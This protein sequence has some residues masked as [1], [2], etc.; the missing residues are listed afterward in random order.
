MGNVT[1]PI[2]TAAEMSSCPVCNQESVAV[3]TKFDHQLYECNHCDHL[4]CL[5]SQIENYVAQTYGDEYF[6]GADGGYVNYLENKNHLINQGRKYSKVL[7]RH[8]PKGQLLDIGSAAG[9]LLKGF[10]DDGWKGVGIEPNLA[11]Q[12]YATHQLNLDVRNLPFDDFETNEKFDAVSLIQVISHLPDLPQTLTRINQLLKP[13]GLFLIE[14]WNRKSMTARVFSKNWH[15]YNPPSV[16]HWFTKTELANLLAQNGFEVIQ[17][18]RPTKWISIGNAAALLRHSYRESTIGRVVTSPL[19]LIPKA[20]KLPYFLD[21]VF[22][23]LA[24]KIGH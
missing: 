24:K 20:I 3:W 16:L 14:T 4:F 18:G 21:D 22:W 15:Q 13:E 1:Q 6:D 23:V 11:M 17:Q 10:V 19:Y 12:T 8:Q 5:P 9:F 2:L 7:S